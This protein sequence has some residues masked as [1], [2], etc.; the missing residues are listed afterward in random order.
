MEMIRNYEDVSIE[1]LIIAL[2]PLPLS[3]CAELCCQA[4]LQTRLTQN[5]LSI[6]RLPSLAYKNEDWL[7]YD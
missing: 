5:L 7:A 4:R 6:L 2:P 1:A 3:R